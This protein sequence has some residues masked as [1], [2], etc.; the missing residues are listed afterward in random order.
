M[1]FRNGASLANASELSALLGNL[2][3][4]GDLDPARIHIKTTIN[5]HNKSYQDIDFNGSF[6]LGLTERDNGLNRIIVLIKTGT[7]TG[8][9]FN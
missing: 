5:H 3:S 6:Q 2:L 9:C 1:L 7:G 8:L 4:S